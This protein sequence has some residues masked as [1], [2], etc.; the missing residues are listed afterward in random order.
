[1]GGGVFVGRVRERA[2][3]QN[4][5]VFEDTSLLLLLPPHNNHLALQ[6]I[7]Q[8]VS[9]RMQKTVVVAVNYVVWVP[10]Y[11]VYEKRVSRHMVRWHS[12]KGW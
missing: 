12:T 1:M 10:K 3:N 8:V 6:T 5:E 11:G 9:N 7:T 4:S 2:C